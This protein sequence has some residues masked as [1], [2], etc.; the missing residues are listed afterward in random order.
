MVAGGANIAIGARARLLANKTLTTNTVYEVEFDANDFDTNNIHDYTINKSSFVINT[1]GL[2]M[3]TGTAGFEPNMNGHARSCEIILNGAV[4]L[5]GAYSE[6]ACSGV[7]INIMNCTAIFKLQKNDV[8]KFRVMQKC[9]SD[10]DL[11]A[12]ET[13]FSIVKIGDM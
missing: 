1:T 5:G 4:Y 12:A 9:G 3:M 8:I 11:R 6:A 13:S 10:L 7:D 2:Y